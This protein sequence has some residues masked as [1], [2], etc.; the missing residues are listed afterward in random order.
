MKALIAIAAALSGAVVATAAPLVDDTHLAA[1]ADAG[2]CL[3]AQLSAEDKKEPTC[4][5][6]GL[7]QVLK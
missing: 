1:V 5:A 2:P 6:G 3:L 7:C 4:I